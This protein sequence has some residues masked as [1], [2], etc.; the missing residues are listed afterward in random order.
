MSDK[1]PFEIPDAVRDMAER[2]VEQARQAYSQF[3]DVAARA[4]DMVTRSSGA[5]TQSAIDIQTKAMRYAQQN[6]E[7]NF[8]L[9]SDLARARDMREYFEIQTRHAQRQMQRYTEQ[10][11]E[12]GRMMSDA[13]QRAQP[14]T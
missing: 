12:L 5:L 8:E 9:A 7:A 2:S 6:I 11:Q 14:R 10:A 13:A 3:L 4:Q 1:A